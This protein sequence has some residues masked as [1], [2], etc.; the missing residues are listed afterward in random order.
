MATQQEINAAAAALERGYHSAFVKLV[1]ELR[2]L[3]ETDHLYA[4]AFLALWEGLPDRLRA[5]QTQDELAAYLGVSRK[6]LYNWRDNHPEFYQQARQDAI[7]EVG[8]HRMA[9]VADKSLT[10]A[11]TDD[12]AYQ[13]RRM[14]LEQWRIID[15]PTNRLTLPTQ[16]GESL[17]IMIDYADHPP[18]F[19]TP[20]PCPTAGN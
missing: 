9:T 3:G 20:P 10:V 2:R 4:K 1:A 16:D 6:T 7:R 19:S 14:W 18:D 12:K 17:R 8:L 5:Q 13:E 15:P 11:E